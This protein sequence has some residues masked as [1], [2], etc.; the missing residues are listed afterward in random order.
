MCFRGKGDNYRLGH[1]TEEHVRV[2]RQL[3]SLAGERVVDVS[4]GA[5]H[6]L[7]VTEGGRVYAWGRNEQGQLGDPAVTCRT[8]PSLMPGL[9]GKKIIGAACGNSQVGIL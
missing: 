3:E 8:E 5:M 9:E 6:V 2:P 4:V 7:A 1:G